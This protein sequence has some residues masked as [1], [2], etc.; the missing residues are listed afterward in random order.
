MSRHHRRAVVVAHIAML[1][2][3]ALLTAT[4][5]LLLRPYDSVTFTPFETDRATYQP[6]DTITL[7]DVFCWDGTPFLSE[8]FFVSQ[9][10]SISAGSVEFPNGFAVPAVAEKY[11]ATGCA[12]TKIHI[13]LPS[14]MPLG[15]WAVQYRVSYRANVI[16]VVTVANT[17]NTFQVVA[18]K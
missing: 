14:T 12:P 2:T 18:A 4:L 8:R 13:E 9:V 10:S 7:T 17:S 5:V 15:E 1:T 16:R 3:L 6:G 11:E